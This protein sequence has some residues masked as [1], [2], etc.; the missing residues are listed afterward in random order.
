MRTTI[1]IL[2]FYF[3]TNGSAAQDASVLSMPAKNFEQ[4]GNLPESPDFILTLDSLAKLAGTARAFAKLYKETTVAI[5]SQSKNL[6]TKAQR[7]T[8]TFQRIF[9]KYFLSAVES[10]EYNQLPASSPWHFYFSHPGLKTWQLQ[11]I[12]VN[13]HVNAD[14]WQALANNFSAEE[15]RGNRKQFL[16]EQREIVKVF[17]PWFE[18]MMG[19]NSY[20]RFM[21]AVTKG[22]AKRMG[23][24]WL[25]KWRER[26]IKLALLYL[27]RPG[28]FQKKFL[29][30]KKKKDKIDRLIM[31]EQKIFL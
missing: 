29:R 24:A 25:Y 11:L 4:T 18:E 7:Y 26:S 28:K 31:K 8:V 12:G 16:R 3:S 15:I 1:I 22:M 5:Y 10:Q 17:E 23:A 19:K 21:N 9:L 27:E 13:A 6:D 2:F 14:I 30:V 20:V